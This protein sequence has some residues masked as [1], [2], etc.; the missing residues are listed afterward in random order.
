MTHDYRQ[1]RVYEMA[2][3]LTS[4]TYRL[5]KTFPSAERFGLV[6]QMNRASVSIASNI[7]E[8]AGRGD[9]R[10]FARFLRISRG[11]ACELEAQATMAV[12]VGLVDPE[13]ARV[14]RAHLEKLKASLTNLEKRISLS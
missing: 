2:I 12:R 1:L 11:S 5:T 3:D 14:L 6:Q 9:S 4:E 8:G 7:A 13:P 10:D